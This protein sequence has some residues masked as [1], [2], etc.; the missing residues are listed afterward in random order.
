[1]PAIEIWEEKGILGYENHTGGATLTYANVPQFLIHCPESAALSQE[2]ASFKEGIQ[3]K[4]V[5]YCHSLSTN[6]R[7]HSFSSFVLLPNISLD[8][9][10]NWSEWQNTRPASK[11]QNVKKSAPAVQQ[12]DP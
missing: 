6:F 8:V 7:N 10:E 4:N 9:S 3:L 11:C 1:M 12:L 2:T 5:A